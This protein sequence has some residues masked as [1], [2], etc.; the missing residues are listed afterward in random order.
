MKVATDG[1]NAIKEVLASNT[2]RGEETIMMC[3]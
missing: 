3:T 2:V 1:S